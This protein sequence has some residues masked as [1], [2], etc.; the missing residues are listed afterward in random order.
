MKYFW[1]WGLNVQEKQ[2]KGCICMVVCDVCGMCVNDLDYSRVS[3]R[4]RIT[5]A[6]WR[7]L[8]KPPTEERVGMQDE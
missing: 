5:Q 1:R 7:L 6:Q 4:F 3:C 8:D 2:D